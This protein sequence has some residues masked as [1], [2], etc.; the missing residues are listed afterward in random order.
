[1]DDLLVTGSNGDLGEKFK[2]D[3]KRTF[4][5][6]YLGEMAYFPRMEKKQKNGEVFFF[7]RC[8]LRK[9]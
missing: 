1:M 2:E 9:F 8:M 3:M 4:E 5:M 7:K 6:T